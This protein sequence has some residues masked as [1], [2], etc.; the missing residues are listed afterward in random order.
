MTMKVFNRIFGQKTAAAAQGPFLTPR[1]VLLLGGI[2][3]GAVGNI[4]KLEIEFFFFGQRRGCCARRFE[5]I[6]HASSHNR[7]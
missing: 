7:R 2:Q 4:G 6:A 5:N 3:G 1:Y